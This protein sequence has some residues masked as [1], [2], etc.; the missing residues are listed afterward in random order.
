M[1]PSAGRG[2]RRDKDALCTRHAVNRANARDTARHGEPRTPRAAVGPGSPGCPDEG[3]VSPR[4]RRRGPGLHRVCARAGATGTASVGSSRR[5][6][7]LLCHSRLRPSGAGADGDRVPDR[8]RPALMGGSASRPGRKALRTGHLSPLPCLGR[9]APK[10]PRPAQPECG[11]RGRWTVSGHRRPGRS[12]SPC[13]LPPS[14][15]HPAS[16]ETRGAV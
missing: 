11:G 15:L 7:C 5:R 3:G 1:R 4:L 12:P 13:A 10:A 9:A 8:Q 6:W 2:Q 14:G 16:G